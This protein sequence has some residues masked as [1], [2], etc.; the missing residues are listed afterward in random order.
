[1]AQ[2]EPFREGALELLPAAA[3]ED[4]PQAR[5]AL[6]DADVG[7]TGAQWGIAETGSLVLESAREHH[8]LISLVPSIHVAL[9]PRFAILG[10]LGEALRAVRGPTGRP[11][12]RTI[13]LITGPSRTADIELQL[14][15]GVHGPRELHVLLTP[16]ETLS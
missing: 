15:V 4:E 12:S 10:S 11:R 6:L 14:V 5:K 2:L 7:V 1:M 3:L 9:L 8:R 16:T 13:T